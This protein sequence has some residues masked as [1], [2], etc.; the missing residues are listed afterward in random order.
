MTRVTELNR[1][2]R[3]QPGY[4]QQWQ[5]KASLQ[6]PQQSAAPAQAPAPSQASSQ[7]TSSSA[8]PGIPVKAAPVSK[9]LSMQNAPR[10]APSP[11]TPAADPWAQRK[12]R[13]Q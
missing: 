12:P 4:L 7:A 9:N 13:S 10:N 2:R 1:L 6:P 8:A 5:A 3:V 11:S